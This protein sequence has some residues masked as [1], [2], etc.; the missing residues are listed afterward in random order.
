MSSNKREPGT[1]HVVPNPLGGWDICRGGAERAAGHFDHKADAVDRG[2]Q[3]SRNAGTELKIHDRE[4][5][6]RR[7]DSHGHDPRKIKG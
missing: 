1:H 6:I 7:S 2:R 5:R 4:G 3:I